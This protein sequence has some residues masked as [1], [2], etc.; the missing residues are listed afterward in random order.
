V[1]VLRGEP[2]SIIYTDANRP[3]RRQ[4]SRWVVVWYPWGLDAGQSCKLIVSSWWVAGGDVHLHMQIERC[5]PRCMACRSVLDR[6]LLNGVFKQIY[7]KGNYY[8][9]YAQGKRHGAG[10][11]RY[12]NGEV[13]NGEWK[14]GAP[15]AFGQCRYSWPDGTK[16]EGEWLNDIVV[17]G[18]SMLAQAHHD[19]ELNP[20][21]E[22]QLD[23]GTYVGELTAPTKQSGR[24]D[25]RDRP[26]KHGLG[27]MQYAN[28]DIYTGEWRADLKH[29]QGK[30][31]WAGGIHYQGDFEGDKMSGRGT[32]TWS[33]GSQS[34][35]GL[36]APKMMGD[37]V[38]E[39]EADASVKTAARPQ[40]SEC[41]KSFHCD[42][43]RR[44]RIK[45]R[46]TEG[47]LGSPMQRVADKDDDEVS[48]ELCKGEDFC[49][50]VGGYFCRESRR[51]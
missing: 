40:P 31:T 27:T 48:H 28:G 51:T 47:G 3:V 25:G 23:N 1:R 38:E 11:M 34:T 30:Y 20:R 45:H 5:N 22:I 26:M 15:K 46:G 2:P 12:D 29:G 39:R 9:S 32:T 8:G 35:A 43:C 44:M 41:S 6:R 33:N 19:V 21:Y 14:D 18:A 42:D 24:S 49:Q 13:F 37:V 36:P 7:A 4:S 10:V 16:F 17:Q 50:I